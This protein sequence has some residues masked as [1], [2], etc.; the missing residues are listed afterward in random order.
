MEAIEHNNRIVYYDILNIMAILAVVA[1]H[2]NGIVHNFSNEHIRAW[3]ISLIVECICY[4]A[5][6]IFLM[7]SG[8]NLM[9]YRDRYN[10]KEFFKKRILKTFIPFIFW[11]IIMGIWKF[12]I[13]Q[14]KIND[15]SI[16]EVLNIFFENKEEYTYYFMFLILG[17]YLTM[18]VLSI[19]SDS[20]YKKICWYIIISIFIFQST[21][22][23]LLQL[24]GIKYNSSFS[25]QIGG[26][27]IFVLLGYLLSNEEFTKDKRIIIY[28][29]A[30]LSVSFRYIFTYY[31]TIV[32]GKL[33]RL[34]F[35]D[36]VQ[37]HSVILAVGVFIFVKTINF[38]N[39]IKNEKIKKIIAK[40]A[41]CSFGIYL[42]HKIIM[43]Y[44]IKI[45]NF[46]IFSWQWRTFAILL[47]YLIC[48]IIIL[49][50]KK[51]PFIKKMVP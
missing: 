50:M 48:L 23:I 25:I 47:T 28:F 13:G 34:L 41:G 51:I 9:K 26:H 44:E 2:H 24:F 30:I 43:Y 37:F 45:F 17:I 19:L 15:F 49:T 5:V 39:I 21:I 6:P 38:D 8:A 22:P 42:L 33:N 31:A 3:S 35:D 36:Y 1:L 29:L 46:N 20:R 40:I 7:L 10:T 32:S 4:W 27:I 16:H 12:A 14:L 11:A 18:P